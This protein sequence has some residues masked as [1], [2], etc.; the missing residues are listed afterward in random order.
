[1]NVAQQYGYTPFGHVGKMIQSPANEA[2][3]HQGHILAGQ[4]G[5]ELKRENHEMGLLQQEQSRRQYDS[6]TQRQKLGVLGG[7]LGAPRRIG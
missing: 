1:M 2:L 6:E 3:S 4:Y 7:L 5:R